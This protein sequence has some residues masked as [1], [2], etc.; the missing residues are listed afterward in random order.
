MPMKWNT[1]LKQQTERARLVAVVTQTM[2]VA[3]DM[4]VHP[5]VGRVEAGPDEAEVRGKN[6]FSKVALQFVIEIRMDFVSASLKASYVSTG[7][8]VSSVASSSRV[9]VC[10]LPSLSADSERGRGGAGGH[11]APRHADAVPFSR[12]AQR[13]EDVRD[14]RVDPRRAAQ[15]RAGQFCDGSLI[16]L[17][18]S[19]NS[20]V[21]SM[22]TRGHSFLAGNVEGHDKACQHRS[23]SELV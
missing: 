2:F 16:C 9:A 19:L 22:C 18:S 17:V 4:R 5:G 8:C 15:R 13:P 3:G 23:L 6:R 21:G 14:S 11:G 7:L 12:D 20:H 10:T 1:A